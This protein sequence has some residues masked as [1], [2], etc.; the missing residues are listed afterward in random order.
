[1]DR[2]GGLLGLRLWKLLLLQV[3]LLAVAGCG[4]EQTSA[5][6]GGSDVSTA[7]DQD[8]QPA[9]GQVQKAECEAKNSE[10]VK[11]Y[12]SI[13]A[14]CIVEID[15]GASCGSG[16]A[17]CRG[18][19]SAKGQC[20]GP[21]AQRACGKGAP[22]CSRCDGQGSCSFYIPGA[23]CKHSGP[24]EC[25]EK[26]GTCEKFGVCSPVPKPVGTACEL[27]NTSECIDGSG[28]CTTDSTCTA[29]FKAKGSPCGN[30]AWNGCESCDGAGKCLA[31]VG[32]DCTT[33]SGD[34][35]GQPGVCNT[36]S[37]CTAIM[38]CGKDLIPQPC[39][40]FALGKACTKTYASAAYPLYC[41]TPTTGPKANSNSCGNAG[42]PC[43]PK[44]CSVDPS[45][46]LTCTASQLP[47]GA[48]CPGVAANPCS[49]ATCLSGKCQAAFKPAGTPCTPLAPKQCGAHACTVAGE[50]AAVVPAVPLAESCTLADSDTD[51]WVK[52]CDSTGTCKKLP[53]AA[54][55]PCG[56]VPD[57][58]C[59]ANRCDG[60]GWCVPQ[61]TSE[62][63]L[64]KHSDCS[65]PTAKPSSPCPV[66]PCVD[67]GCKKLGLCQTTYKPAG[68]GCKFGTIAGTCDESH[69]CVPQ[70]KGAQWL[71][72]QPCIGQFPCMKEDVAYGED[73]ACHGTIATGEI[74]GTLC[75]PGICGPDGA[76]Q[77][78]PAPKGTACGNTTLCGNFECDGNGAC[79]MPE[80]TLGKSCSASY[81]NKLAECQHYACSSSGTCVATATVGKACASSDPCMVGSCG[82]A[83]T[84]EFKPISG[85]VCS[86]AKPDAC[87]SGVCKVGKCEPVPK[88]GGACGTESACIAY[89]CDAKGGCAGIPKPGASCES[90]ETCTKGVCDLAGQCTQVL[91]PGGKCAGKEQC[92]EGL[93]S[94]SGACQFGPKAAGSPC[95]AVAPGTNWDCYT[96]ACDGKGGCAL[97]VNTGAK[98]K[99]GD[100]PCSVGVCQSD[101]SC[102]AV[103]ANLG[104]TC[105]N[106]CA[107][108]PVCGPTGKCE[109]TPLVGKVCYDECLSSATCS[110]QGQCVGKANVGQGCGTG[111]MNQI[112]T[113][114]TCNS[115]GKC[116]K[117]ASPAGKPCDVGAA[118]PPDNPVYPCGSAKGTCNDNGGCVPASP[119]PDG[120]PCG[121]DDGCANAHVCK[122][123]LCL[124][125]EPK[126]NATPCQFGCAPG[127]CA[128]GACM[129]FTSMTTSNV[130]PCGDDNPCTYSICIGA[131]L[132]GL[133]GW[134]YQA[135]SEWAAANPGKCFQEWQNYQCPDGKPPDLTSCKV[136]GCPKN[137]CGTTMICKLQDRGGTCV[138]PTGV[139]GMGTSACASGN[140]CVTV[141]CGGG[142]C[143]YTPVWD[144]T[145]CGAFK[146][147]QNGE[148]VS[149][150]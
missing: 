124:P 88:P 62:K 107:T 118:S 53:R 76:C 20:V 77:T 42:D 142:Q 149:F 127:T 93:C 2:A 67:S 86:L 41:T 1:M 37:Y 82:A 108:N 140:P 11:A 23:A 6:D 30:Y 72:G 106:Q 40:D 4:L 78:V 123:G 126:A 143:T 36:D 150:E 17:E 71:V 70:G 144:P 43:Q 137:G 5:T 57:N 65:L 132:G 34:C 55:E 121:A 69:R 110:A 125:V 80:A 128:A 29:L 38:P 135:T 73:G 15:A 92:M 147:C 91:D 25:R 61:L 59:I 3:V 74:C 7:A 16:P 96:G 12:W 136:V 13:A 66:G 35:A 83:G 81:L 98:C 44:M 63:D 94:T 87:N 8:A 19:C 89:Q 116:V 100:G 114:N 14:A 79:A 60:K 97:K 133:K 54:G 9:N 146:H 45:V 138:T 120:T 28:F 26:E 95:V 68:A 22:E 32:T 49:A 10:C 103:P 27:G 112:C 109:G 85:P 48:P 104:K 148:C 130:G 113:Q 39:G 58:T 129:A 47:D 46:P 90:T 84:C 51:C 21:G 134:G 122:G 105:P 33:P 115:S 141:G 18:T 75:K 56:V 111:S 24:Q 117:Q 31:N 131:P 119:N 145:P 99:E 64:C 50:C 52:S 101:A 102:K 139:P